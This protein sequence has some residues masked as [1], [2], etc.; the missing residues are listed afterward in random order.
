MYLLSAT[1]Y[2]IIIVKHRTPTP[3][4]INLSSTL[5]KSSIYA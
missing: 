5:S 2:A 3:G 4:R 1:L